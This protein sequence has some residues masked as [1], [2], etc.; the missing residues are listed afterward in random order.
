M[1]NALEL[2]SQST[3]T[4][5][6]NK[7]APLS[8]RHS[9]WLLAN[10]PRVDHMPPEI[11]AQLPRILHEA[12]LALR[13]ATEREFAVAIDPLWDWAARFK[14]QAGVKIQTAKYR[15]LLGHLPAD[16]LAHAIRDVVENHDYRTIPLPGEIKKRASDEYER[17]RR[18][19]NHAKTMAMYLRWRQPK[20]T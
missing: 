4:S 7:T 1:Q 14:I 5:S 6:G 3:L 2:R 9:D 18:I 17:R 11:V 16:V 15:E 13:P 19:K 20:A 12:E 10:L 8:C